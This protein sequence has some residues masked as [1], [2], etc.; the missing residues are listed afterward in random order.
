MKGIN[1][2]KIA[3]FAAG[4]IMLGASVAVADVV[5]GS[6]PLVNQNG[7]PVVKIVVG[8]NAM[9]SDGVAAGNIAAAIANQAYKSSTLTASVSGEATCAAGGSTPGTST[10]GCSISNEKVTL[11]VT[12]PGSNA[13]TATIATLV[14]DFIDRTTLNRNRTAS[15]DKYDSSL[16]ELSDTVSPFKNV[17][18]STGETQALYKV[19]SDFT[20]FADYAIQD[21]KSDLRVTENQA[22]WVA[23][24]NTFD[25]SKDD[26]TS[27]LDM[28]AYTVKFAGNDYGI[29]LCT[30]DT[31]GSDYSSCTS[32]SAMTENHRVPLK[33]LGSQWVI[34]EITKPSTATA[35]P[36]LES[37]AVGGVVKIAKESSYGIINV[38]DKL[39]S[40]EVQIKLSDISVAT[41]STNQHPA[42]LDILDSSGKVISQQQVNPGDTYNYRTDTGKS[43]RIHVYQTSPGFTLNAKWAEMAVYSDELTLTSGSSKVDDNN[44]NWKPIITWKNKEAS[45]TDTVTD[46]LRSIIIYADNTLSGNSQMTDGF[47]KGDS[48]NIIQSPS[49]FQLTYGGLD[50]TADDYSQLR[51][52]IINRDTFVVAAGAGSQ[53][54][55]TVGTFQENDTRLVQ[56]TSATPNA[57][58]VNGESVDTMFW[59]ME[60]NSQ[61]DNQYVYYK[62]ASSTESCYHKL[63]STAGGQGVATPQIKFSVA[64]DNP[65]YG[66]INMTAQQ[67]TTNM[68][69]TRS[70]TP[71]GVIQ[72]YEDGGKFQAQSSVADVWTFP[73]F[74]TTAINTVGSY[75]FKPTTTSTNTQMNYT[76]VT[77]GAVSG[78]TGSLSNVDTPHI[79]ERGSMFTDYSTDV[80]TIK[81][82]KKPAKATW[83]L[84]SSGTTSA[85]GAQEITLAEGDTQSVS[86]VSIMA[87]SITESVGAC[88]AS[89]SGGAP[90]C[91]VD[92][93]GVK[94]KIVDAG[95]Y[96]D[97]V[98][99]LEP[100][101]VGKLVVL[102]KDASSSDSVVTVG[103]PAV[104]TVTADALAGAAVDFNTDRVVVKEVG[105]KIVVAGLSADDTLA[106]A[107]RFIA[108]IKRQ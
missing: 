22:L 55:C 1:M 15:E 107:D 87:K 84:A 10:G 50:L 13:G 40:G 47:R 101:K 18:L 66:S 74:G 19:G 5:Y 106:A 39:D 35:L 81:I 67:N 62:T 59:S 77:G 61:G 93:T 57:F 32:T 8:E 38:G 88:T 64:G 53:S 97:S 52:A 36:G 33:F 68:G 86:G 71:Y 89:V 98:E 91:T 14:N 94:A 30:S 25:T 58:T 69:A 78:L 9:A 92:Q 70:F 45:A 16:S 20:P 108:G 60:N 6:T 82:A 96:K 95:E 43:I 56:I 3:A 48:M 46:S 31:N 79:S 105:K 28:V 11:E 26:V 21:P 7:Q 27:K 23:G 17:S 104:N 72:V 76:S 49:P 42:I 83:T 34:S 80:V 12:V 37:A 29:P 2:K 103:G 63:A 102:D 100:Y 41:G 4:A 51:F 90:S 75:S 44:A 85:E 99:T 54:S 24:K 73:I 65:A